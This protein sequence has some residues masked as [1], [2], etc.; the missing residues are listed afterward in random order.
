[1]TLHRGFSISSGY[2]FENREGQHLS[3]PI[4]NSHSLEIE[5]NKYGQLSN[6]IILQFSDDIIVLSKSF[7]FAFYNEIVAKLNFAKLFKSERIIRIKSK[8]YAENRF[9]RKSMYNFSIQSL[10]R[11]VGFLCV[12]E[13]KNWNDFMQWIALHCNFGAGASFLFEQFLQK[14]L[15]FS[16]A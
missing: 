10:C 9:H 12:K 3:F 11:G 15:K 6:N 13:E 7:L 5:L 2:L 8:F 4:L 14:I 16:F 1:M